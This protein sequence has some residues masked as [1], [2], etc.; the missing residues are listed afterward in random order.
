MS[1]SAC[2]QR[3]GVYG[4]VVWAGNVLHFRHGQPPS[5]GGR[6]KCMPSFL[7]QTLR[8]VWTQAGL[9]R[10]QQRV[11]GQRGDR[12]RRSLCV[13]LGFIKKREE[14]CPLPGAVVMPKRGILGSTPALSGSCHSRKGRAHNSGHSHSGARDG[15]GGGR[16]VGVSL[17]A[18]GEGPAGGGESAA[19][20][21]VAGGRGSRAR[22]AREGAQRA[23]GGRPGRLRS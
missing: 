10:G 16:G 20:F 1:G 21:Q 5:Q 4:W 14:K 22:A 3:A 9:G 8:C 12:E 13:S 2:A 23:A 15:A 11:A 19:Q 7:C 6:T 17:G 18:C